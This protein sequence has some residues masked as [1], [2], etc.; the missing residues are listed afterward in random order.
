MGFR[1]LLPSFHSGFINFKA[2]TDALERWYFPRY[3]TPESM[4]SDTAMVFRSRSFSD[5]Y[6]KW[7]ITRINT[8]PDYP[9]GSQMRVNPYLEAT[10]KVFHH[11]SQKTWDKDLPSLS[12][13]FNTATHDSPQFTTANLFLGREINSPL[14]VRW[15]LS[16]E[17]SEKGN[18]N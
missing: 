17:G 18:V 5:L 9:K 1:S 3:G 11:R 2:V 7:R 13:A 10:L 6:F 4:V 16:S 14:Q 12:S 8:I 15:D